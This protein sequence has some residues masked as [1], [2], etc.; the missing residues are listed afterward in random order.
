MTEFR[1]PINACPP[2]QEA[3]SGDTLDV[4]SPLVEP[5]SATQL[6]RV[7]FRIQ[8]WIQA[9]RPAAHLM[10]FLPLFIGQVFVFHVYQQ[11]SLTFF[12]YTLLFGALYQ[13]FLLYLNDYADEAIDLTNEQY[14]LSG[15]SRVLPQ[16]KLQ[17]HDLLTGAK[18]ALVVMLAL[19]FYLAVFADRPWM[20]VGAALAI[21]LCWAYNLRPLQLSYRGHGEILQGLGCGALLPLGGFYLQH[22]SLQEFPWIALA[23]LYLIFHAG[24]IVTALPDYRSDK[25]GHKNTH[26][27]RHGERRARTTALILLAIAHVG[28]V[29]ASLHL[30]PI[31]L[32][33]M[34]LPS[35][36]MLVLIVKSGMLRKADAAQFPICK[37]FVT[38]VSASQ[39]WLLG[40]W[41]GALLLAGSS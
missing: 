30:P 9:A 31:G 1:T 24:N 11:F 5:K 8:P 16:G 15:G 20:P 21:A 12:M 39:A 38:W 35:G 27:V 19:S 22:G 14:F 13:I 36:L 7:R 17:P 10:I 2:V 34:V 6:T 26:P 29:L 25:E 41:T 32:A 28:V 33:I 23:P 3:N 40:A 37:R 18:A 4:P